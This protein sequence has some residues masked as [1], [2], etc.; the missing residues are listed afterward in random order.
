[1][2][3][4]ELTYPTGCVCPTCGNPEYYEPGGLVKGKDGHR[5]FV[6]GRVT[7]HEPDCTQLL[8]ITYEGREL[9]GEIKVWEEEG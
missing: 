9:F 4:K 1:M 7:D 5:H 8:M 3:I 2:P 6:A